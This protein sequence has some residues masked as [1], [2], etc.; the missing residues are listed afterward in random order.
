MHSLQCLQLIA[1]SK[2]ALLTILLLHIR[3]SIS[4]LTTAGDTVLINQAEAIHCPPELGAPNLEDCR[5]A[6]AQ[7]AAEARIHDPMTFEWT[8]PEMVSTNQHLIQL[9]FPWDYVHGTCTISIVEVPPETRRHTPRLS[10][11]RTFGHLKSVASRALSFCVLGNRLGG[12]ALE[13]M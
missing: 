6:L 4:V 7:L 11:I 13:G 5:A 2:V 12:Y 3:A 10:T 1:L 8:S 9:Q